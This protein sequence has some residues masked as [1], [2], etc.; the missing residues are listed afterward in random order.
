MTNNTDIDSINFDKPNKNITHNGI[1]NGC[2]CI[3]VIRGTQGCALVGDP[4]RAV[5]EC[6]EVAKA[7]P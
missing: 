6:N 2:P 5:A 3:V 4:A 1:E 7:Q